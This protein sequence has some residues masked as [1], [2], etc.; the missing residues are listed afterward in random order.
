MDD[1]VCSYTNK[2][3]LWSQVGCCSVIVAVWQWCPGHATDD[4]DAC[5]ERRRRTTFIC[6]VGVMGA[7]PRRR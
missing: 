7:V 2:I 4:D 3:N 6:Q 5:E 1:A